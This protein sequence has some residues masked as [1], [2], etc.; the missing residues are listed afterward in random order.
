M[1]RVV[2]P[3]THTGVTAEHERKL[4][5]RAVAPTGGGGM[6]P[7]NL[8]QYVC[9]GGFNLAAV[10]SIPWTGGGYTVT[11]DTS[12]DAT[13]LFTTNDVIVIGPD[14]LIAI[15]LDVQSNRGTYPG[16]EVVVELYNFT[17]SMLAA[18]AWAPDGGGGWLARL[19]VTWPC[20][21]GESIQ[22]VP[23]VKAGAA[24]TNVTAAY[25]NMSRVL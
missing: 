13:D 14:S 4:K 22:A 12:W 9:N 20:W 16:Q 3:T 24:A 15:T 11:G 8:V 2:L 18:A 7:N 1:S 19:S 21:A 5:R 6:L 10:G 25:L 17:F 23:M